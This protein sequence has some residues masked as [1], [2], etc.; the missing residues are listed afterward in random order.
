MRD[1]QVAADLLKQYKLKFKGG[2]LSVTWN[3][4]RDSMSTY[5][6]QTNPVSTHREGQGHLRDPQF[7]LDAFQVGSSCVEC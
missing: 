1:P 7:Q 5:L 4:L 3:Y 2:A 6:S